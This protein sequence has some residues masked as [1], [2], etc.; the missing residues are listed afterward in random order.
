MPDIVG[1]EH[2]EPTSLQAIGNKAKAD[3]QHRFQN[4]YRCLNEDLLLHCWGDLNKDA[5]SGVDGMSAQAY[6]Q[7]LHANIEALAQKLRSKSYH[8]KLVRRHYIPKEGSDKLRPLGIPAIEDKLVQAACAKLLSAI[9][10]QDFMESSY[11]YRPGR[12]ALDA[13]Y[14]LTG[15]LQTGGYGY[16]VEA[17]VKGF[18]DHLDHDKLLEMLSLRVDDRAFLG[19]LRK[20]L[21]AG[22]L[23]PE[24]NILYPE[25]GT[26]Q[27][28]LVSPILANVY[29]HHVL[30]VW[31][32]Q[33]VKSHC[34][35]DVLLCRYAD[36]WLCAFRYSKD[37]EAF[38]R[39]LP[40]RLQKFN[41]EVAP[42]K[43][44][45][46]RFS[47]YHPSM[48]R[49]FTFLGFEFF[50]TED[51]QGKP[52]VMRRTARKKLQGAC[53]R[54]KEWIKLNRHLP[55]RKFFD[56]LNARLRGHYNYYGIRGNSRALSRVYEWAKDNA[57]KWLNRRGGKRRSYTW[58]RF[59]Q[60][61]DIVQLARPRIF[62]TRYGRVMPSR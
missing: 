16:V 59:A 28:G 52:R 7:D 21:K 42:E 49:R 2:H 11:G 18:F 3:K 38:Y 19:L 51:R 12:G 15:A 9:Y 62:T 8:A 10:E 56:G 48:T 40:K 32:E 31:F 36:D 45:L 13:V 29:L 27:G 22:I 47:R 24:G 43:T 39:V 54:I 30:D 41:L 55:V 6:A 57:F 20:W 34:Q 25:A 60:V 14:D 5:A 37:A 46:L 44:R 26:P 53:R 35:G 17:D 61:L 50:W 1:S 23:E 4:L 58:E 33:V